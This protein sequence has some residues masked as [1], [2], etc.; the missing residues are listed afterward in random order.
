[1]AIHV[2]MFITAIIANTKTRLNK[3]TALQ[4]CMIILFFL[5]ALRYSVGNDYDRY[6]E[7]FDWF[8]C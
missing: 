1:M 3:K 6:K 8:H 4:I 7:L 2:V 5:S